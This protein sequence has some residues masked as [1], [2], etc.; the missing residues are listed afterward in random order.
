[1]GSARICSFTR[2]YAELVSK[3]FDFFEMKLF[4]EQFTVQFERYVASKIFLGGI[5]INEGI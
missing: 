3:K 2:N 5:I 1:M 4:L